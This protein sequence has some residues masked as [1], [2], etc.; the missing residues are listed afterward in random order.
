MTRGYDR[1]VSLKELRKTEYADLVPIAT[2]F[3]HEVVMVDSRLRWKPNRLIQM[4]WDD[5]PYGK[6]RRHLNL[7][8]LWDDA[9]AG[10]FS[11]E[12]LVKLHMQGGYSLCGF[13]ELF[14]QTPDKLRLPK[15]KT[16]MTVIKYLTTTHDGKTL[17]L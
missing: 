4:L 6:K 9:A 1:L 8:A 5:G 13:V 3:N 7:S 14:D 11:L 15:P 17:S 10:R 12:E 16:R 2:I